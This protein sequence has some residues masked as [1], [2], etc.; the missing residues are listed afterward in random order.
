MMP[1]LTM[2]DVYKRLEGIRTQG[3]STQRP[4]G[5]EQL[6]EKAKLRRKPR[7]K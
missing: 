2:D 1:K 7:V 6:V 5:I 4:A 3:G